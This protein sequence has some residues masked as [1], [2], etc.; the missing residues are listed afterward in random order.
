MGVAHHSGC[1]TSTESMLITL[2]SHKEVLDFIAHAAKHSDHCTSD[3]TPRTPILSISPQTLASL[4]AHYSALTGKPPLPLRT[5]LRRIRRF[6]GEEKRG[7]WRVW[8]TTFSRHIALQES[9]KEFEERRDKRDK[10]KARDVGAGVPEPGPLPMLASACPGWVCYAEKA[11]G[12]LLPLLSASRSPQ[13]VM[14]ALAKSW[15]ANRLDKTP[16]Q[17]YHVTAMPCYDK[18]LEA[19]RSDFYS[20]V[21]STRETD[22]V[23]TT[24]ELDLLLQDLGFNPWETAPG[25]E[26][27]PTTDVTQVGCSPWPEMIQHAGSSSGSYLQTLISAIVAS[28]PNP[29][30]LETREIRGSS[31]NVEFLLE[32]AVTGQVIFKGAKCYGFRNLQNLVRKVGKETGI[33]K[34]GRAGASKLSAAIAAR[35]RKARTNASATSTPGTPGTPGDSD[36]EMVSQKEDKKLD[37]VEV[38]ACPGGCVNGGGQMKPV[39]A[40]AKVNGNGSAKGGESMDVDEEGYPRPMADD[41]VER[42]PPASAAEEGMRWSTKEWVGKVEEIYWSGLPTPPASPPL[43]AEG[44]LAAKS[45]VLLKADDIARDILE[46]TVGGDAVKRWELLRTR[47]RKVEGDVLGQ[48][49]VSHEAVK[50]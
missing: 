43:P 12:D 21:Y 13:A 37:F 22:C 47:F 29:T 40:A 10:G 5:L 49:G 34:T 45:D 36:A 46:E 26:E 39:S 11:Q 23:L 25:E 15:F 1:I 3:H 18:K 31:D 33:S 35:R 50:W 38:M 14:G 2:Q 8:D 16:D 17:V 19:S 28:H 30:R 48:G 27:E 44:S 9:V 32:D 42:A 20:S 6:M 24:G 4:S 7:G 41:G